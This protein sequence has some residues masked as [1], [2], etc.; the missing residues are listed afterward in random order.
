MSKYTMCVIGVYFGKMPAYF[1]LWLKSCELNPDVD[2]LIITDNDLQGL[3]SNVS[4]V[5]M[6][7]EEM[8]SLADEKLGL[9]TSLTQPYKCCDFKVVYGNI[10]ESYLKKYD[11][12]GHCDFDLIFG[13]IR[14]FVT[15]E[16]LGKYDKIFDLGHF[17]LYRNTYEVN[18]RY[19]LNGAYCDYLKVFTTPQSYAFDERDG[20]YKIYKANKFSVYDKIVYLDIHSIFSR[21]K[22]AHGIKNH[23]HQIFFWEN[24]KVYMAYKKRNKIF[25][26]EYV[27]IHFKKRGFNHT[28]NDDVN[29]FYISNNGFIEKRHSDA[30]TANKIK[31][32]N[33]IIF[34]KEAK[35]YISYG[36]KVISQKISGV[37]RRFT[38]FINKGEK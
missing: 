23:I 12:W 11:F 28:L 14:A 2:F 38:D 9:D 18:S 7:L 30:T 21:F 32:I 24:G 34:F 5:K 33:K 13:D 17:S 22:P 16:I 31:E 29:S 20:I 6:T 26:D 25:C 19:K 3:P 35:E 1:N 4:M 15:D 8:K 37:K 10:F 27:Y 36:L